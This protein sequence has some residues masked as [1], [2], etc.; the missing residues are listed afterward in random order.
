TCCRITSGLP[1]A[2]HN[3]RFLPAGGIDGALL[4]KKRAERGPRNERIWGRGC[5]RNLQA[6]V[7]PSS[8]GGDDACLKIPRSLIAPSPWNHGDSRGHKSHLE[9]IR[10]FCNTLSLGGE[11]KR[12]DPPCCAIPAR[13]ISKVNTA[14]K[15]V[16]CISLK[17]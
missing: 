6:G 2:L 10:A 5:M 15:P 16:H 13:P 4:F 1:T 9:S 17:K 11:G 7:V 3:A 8:R 14:A 12:S